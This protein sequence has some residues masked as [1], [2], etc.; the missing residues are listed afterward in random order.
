M[1]DPI[2]ECENCGE[3]YRESDHEIED[4]DPGL[5]RGCAVGG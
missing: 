1:K 5:C 4:R 2:I 3:S